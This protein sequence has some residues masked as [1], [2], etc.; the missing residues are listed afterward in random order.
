MCYV[1]VAGSAV[2][3]TLHEVASLRW[4]ATSISLYVQRVFVSWCTSYNHIHG[5]H[6]SETKGTGKKGPATALELGTYALSRS[7]SHAS[8]GGRDLDRSPWLAWLK[9]RAK[10]NCPH[11]SLELRLTP[12]SDGW[13]ACLKHLHAVSCQECPTAHSFAN[14][15]TCCRRCGRGSCYS[16]VSVAT[17]E[18]FVA[19]AS[20]CMFYCFHSSTSS[21]QFHCCWS[22]QKAVS[23]Q[24]TRQEQ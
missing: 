13:S 11:V 8:H 20:Y 12:P 24:Q 9:L 17:D 4:K 1:I 15:I 5:T 6:S 21:I 16:V 3:S 14:S 7:F 23:D 18:T 10:A 19:K 2:P 22:Q